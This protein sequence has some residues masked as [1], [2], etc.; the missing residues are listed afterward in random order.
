MNETT[1]VS[2]EQRSARVSVVTIHGDL[3]SVG[4]K[5]VEQQFNAAIAD[6]TGRVVV[7]LSDVEFISSAGLAMIL[8]RGKMLNR[9]GGGL[10][11]AGASRRVAEVLSMA[12]FQ[13]LFDIYPTL[14]E[15]VAAVQK[16]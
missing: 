5:M 8:V 1:T 13:E 11:V 6:R 16:V 10:S 4:V 9:A 3:D 14:D 2:V 15:A 7:D 12:G